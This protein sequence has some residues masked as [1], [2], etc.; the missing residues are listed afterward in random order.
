MGLSRRFRTSTALV[1]LLA[2]ASCGKKPTAPA[3]I[4]GGTFTVTDIRC[5]GGDPGATITA[6]YTSPNVRKIKITGDTA[7]TT[8]ASP[9]CTILSQSLVSYA[10]PGRASD[11]KAFVDTGGAYSCIPSSCDSI[12]G[13]MVTNRRI[14]YDIVQDDTT[15]NLYSV[16]TDPLC[17]DAGQADGV[18]YTLTRD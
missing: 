13:T 17:T 8:Q 1:F 15:L 5:N 9:S 10:K 14:D 11:Y 12:C 16:D 2:A 4:I 7:I 3:D 6:L 18:Y